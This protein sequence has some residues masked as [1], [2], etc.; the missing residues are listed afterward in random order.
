MAIPAFFARLAQAGEQNRVALD[1][2]LPLRQFGMLPPQPQASHLRLTGRDI[3]ASAIKASF[4]LRPQ[5]R[6][7]HSIEQQRKPRLS[8]SLP[9]PAQQI[10]NPWRPMGRLYQRGLFLLV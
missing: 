10:T 7:S 3:P 8:N 1:T 5:W 2:R 4:S 9:Q 6:R